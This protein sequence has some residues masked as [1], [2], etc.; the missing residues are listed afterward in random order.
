MFLLIFTNKE[1][2]VSRPY[3]ENIKEAENINVMD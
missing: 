1:T 2:E 3:D